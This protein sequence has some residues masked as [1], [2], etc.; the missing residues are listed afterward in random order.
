MP[1]IHIPR[2]GWNLRA[3]QEQFWRALVHE[4]KNAVACWHRRF[5]K[6]EVA[7]NALA[8]KAM[9]RPA[10]YAYML[11]EIS[12]AR[13]A[14]WQAVNPHTGKR[15]ILETFQPEMLATDPNETEMRISLVNGSQVLFFG[16][17]QYDRL[18]G[19]SLAGIISS[20]HAL[21]HPS[22][23][24]YFSPM[25]RENNG[26]FAAI[27]TPR[28]RNH[29]HDLFNYAGKAKGWFA[30][31]LSI[32][33]T[34][35]LSP[36]E[37]EEAR[38]EY[39]AMY[40][41]DQGTALFQQEYEVSFNAAIMGAFYGH[42]MSAVRSE[43]RI[44]AV[45]PLPDRPVHRAWDIGVRDDTSI[46]WFQVAG[47]QVFILDCY[48]T[49][50]VGLEHYAD[51][52]RKRDEEHGWNDGMQPIDFV[53]HDAKVKEWASG[54]TRVETMLEY[55][56]N[57]QLCVSA[58]KLD[59]IN[60]ARKTIQRAVFHPRTEDL[61]IA[62]L[63]QYRREWDD[64]KKA[65]RASEVHDWTSHLADAFRYLSLSWQSVP[66]HEPRKVVEAPQG[67]FVPPPVSQGRRS[68]F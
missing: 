10:S 32:H 35:A 45:E 15:R 58:T 19:A 28:G 24:G 62:A 67:Y 53:P 18:V 16:S 52:V 20:E 38:A 6:D 63:E 51:V 60:A 56:L 36:E 4:N 57:P 55:G 64:E 54:R 21:A 25:L 29:F 65:F 66:I 40:G 34:G 48:S 68:R 47:A 12:H 14:I 26:F 37:I 22:A 11:P 5:G 39:V 8:V 30:E 23:Y 17:D 44:H 46:W 31:R 9:Q 27:S 7:L 49:N 33:D 61:G 50:G 13:R 2:I 41:I 3:G 43:G 1:E 59:G 42:E